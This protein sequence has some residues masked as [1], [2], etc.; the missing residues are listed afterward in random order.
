M[1]LGRQEGMSTIAVMVLVGAASGIVLTATKIMDNSK[2]NFKIAQVQSLIDMEFNQLEFLLVDPVACVNTFGIANLGA[3]SVATATPAAPIPVQ[4]IWDGRDVLPL[5][6]GPDPADPTI[7]IN[8]ANPNMSYF[9]LNPSL[10]PSPPAAPAARLF[11]RS[12]RSQVL[13]T[14]VTIGLGN[15][16][17]GPLAFDNRLNLAN[18]QFVAVFNFQMDTVID[19]ADLTAIKSTISTSGG[20]V[21]NF[22]RTAVFNAT[23]NGAGQVTSCSSVRAVLFDQRFVN[24]KRD[25]RVSVP[26]TIFGRVN[27][28][29]DP[30]ADWSGYVRAVRLF[31]LSDERQK[32]DIQPLQNSSDILSKIDG[33]LFDW[34]SGPK[35]DSGIIAQNVEQVLPDLII[36]EQ[37][38]KSV[39]YNSLIALSASALKEELHATQELEESLAILKKRIQKL[40]ENH[41]AV[42]K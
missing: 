10:P 42:K 20:I 1:I 17:G 15:N 30:A 25:D 12:Q 22:S 27:V 41:N 28:I 34:K 26:L 23:F 2:K 31:S 11:D 33:K 29:P 32:E 37:G 7:V 8:T 39:N 16:T 6:T 9:P 40:K 21:T 36:G 13:L 18:N 4:N 24:M 19:P 14:S 5:G 38:S 35:N 3:A